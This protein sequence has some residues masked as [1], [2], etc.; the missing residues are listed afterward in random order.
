MDSQQSFQVLIVE[1]SA[2]SGKTFALAKRFLYL[3]LNPQNC[4]QQVALRSILA[5]TFTNKATVEMK[6]RVLELLKRLA[7][8]V[9]V[10]KAQEQEI[11]KAVGLSKEE[12]R[13]RAY[14]ALDEMVRHYNFFSVKTIDSLINALLLGC[15]LRIDR[16]ASFKIKRSYDDY[17]LFSLDKIIDQAQGNPELYKLFEDFLQHYLFVENR[18]G[19]FPKNDILDL[20]KSLFRM[21]NM[22]GG[23][24]LVYKGKSFQIIGKKKELYLQIQEII[25]RLPDGINKRAAQS[26]ESF[27]VN[28]KLIFDTG[29]LPDWL[30]D[31]EPPMNKDK[32]APLAF[33]K[34]WKKISR[35]V[36][37]LVEAEASLVYNPYVELFN[38]V[39]FDFGRDSRRDDVLFL[40]ELNR[41]A[42]S[43]FGDDGVTAA[44]LYYR[45]ATRFN[46]Y[47][48]DEFQ[49]T[50]NLQ[51]DNLEMMVAEALS[52]GGSLF[53]VGD[54]KQAIYRFR[55]GE[56][57]LFEGIKQRFEQYPQSVSLLSNNWRSHKAIVGFNNL[58]FTRDNLSC[59]ISSSGIAK[60]MN[61]DQEKI[62][63]ILD[64]FNGHF[65]TFQE[66][67]DRG[68]V[69]VEFL[70]EE[71]KQDRDK[72]VKEKFLALL[73][74]LSPRFKYSDI[75]ILTGNNNEVELVSGWLI[76]AGLSVESE[77]TLDL[78]LNFQIK[79]IISFLSFLYSPIDDLAF[80]SFILNDVFLKAAGFKYQEIAD[81]LFNQGHAAD[82]VNVYRAFR[83]AYPKVWEELIEEFF[84]TV[85]FVSVYELVRSIYSR[86]QVMD[87]FPFSESF[88]MKFLELIKLC[89]EECVGLGEFLMYFFKEQE[90]NNFYVTTS[91]HEAIQVLTIHKSKGLEFDVVILPFLSIDIKP[92]NAG[93]LKSSY[94]DDRLS[95]GLGLLRITKKYR[96]FSSLLSDI[97]ARAYQKACMDELNKVYVALTRAKY[98]MYIFI[99]AKSGNSN[100]LV[101]YLI[102]RESC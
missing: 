25:Q 48:I 16:S 93:G 31:I 3:L 21:T 47:L 7:L 54:K 9:F 71:N 64:V 29:D 72:I 18:N 79:G 14:N 73:A 34:D 1:A 87:N 12:A 56:S 57:G 98:E 99:P 66:T 35:E 59:M 102:T 69:R 46:H 60:E 10:D 61:N 39:I 38:Q 92:D 4:D 45:L 19:W 67:K 20:L 15:S 44:E 27:V 43:L 58:V 84:K 95:P 65:Q 88:F 13:K 26:L 76:E 78:R 96:Q 101:K 85:G 40:E 50:S 6:E 90:G 11:L 33:L 80:G 5:I 77:K 70:K 52:S 49:D 53:Y 17:L 51:W 22:Y 41:K 30:A 62:K 75:T 63:E 74:Q 23:E 91:R 28:N 68:Y 2:G 81:F 24:F 42:N 86:Y 82:K 8:D 36:K 97:Y 37:E 100:N 83:K 89:E 94:V 32:P 55:G